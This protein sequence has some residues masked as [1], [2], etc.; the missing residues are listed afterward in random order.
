MTLILS[1]ILV[2]GT[3][4][5]GGPFADHVPHEQLTHIYSYS[6]SISL[7]GLL[8]AS[9][10][11]EYNAAAQ[12]LKTV[13]DES[14][15]ARTLIAKMAGL[16]SSA[17]ALAGMGSWEWDVASGKETWSDNFY[18]IMGWSPGEVEPS[19][20][21]FLARIHPEDRQM[22]HSASQRAIEDQNFAYEVEF[23]VIVANGQTR[24]I[25]GRGRVEF[26]AQGRAFRMFGMGQDV[27]YL[28]EMEAQRLRMEQQAIRTAQLAMVGELS[29]GVAHEINNPN[30]SINFSASLL[31]GAWRDAGPILDGHTVEHGDF[32]LG[33]IPYSS[34]RQRIPKLLSL[35]MENSGRIKRIIENIKGMARPSQGTMARVEMEAVVKKV[36]EILAG[37]IKKCTDHFEIDCVGSDLWVHGDAGELEQVLTNLVAN[38]L[39]SLPSRDQ[40]VSIL[41]RRLLREGQ[42]WVSIQVI[43]QGTGIDDAVMA[44]IFQPFFTTKGEQG[45]TGLGLS[46]SQTIITAYGGEILIDSTVGTGTTVTV[47]LPAYT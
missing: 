26:D 21:T 25:M 10:T 37:R 28:R 36:G 13:Y 31:A 47:L 4:A 20:E 8:V 24:I 39:E 15:Q 27:T 33:G 17:E 42:P 34:M 19:Y 32:M 30:N 11:E 3:V 46:I 35:I 5:M 7:I 38:A 43:D 44:Q 6:V 16:I 18:R 2:F 29:A 45:G 41:V 14:Q 12:Q 40:R 1:L 22:I 23:R 9:A